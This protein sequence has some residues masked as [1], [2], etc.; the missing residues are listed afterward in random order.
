MNKGR[1]ISKKTPEEKEALEKMERL[2]MGVAAAETERDLYIRKLLACSSPE[3]FEALGYQIEWPF[4][5]FSSQEEEDEYIQRLKKGL[6][7]RMPGLKV[8]DWSYDPLSRH[9]ARVVRISWDA[10]EHRWRYSI[11]GFSSF[12]SYGPNTDAPNVEFETT[13]GTTYKRVEKI[14]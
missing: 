7:T 9:N 8:G 3:Q 10:M 13:D 4:T 6:P 11:P 1:M 2:K 5:D 12:E 14:A